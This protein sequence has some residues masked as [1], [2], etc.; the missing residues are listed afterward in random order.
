MRRTTLALGALV[1][2]LGSALPAQT[3]AITGGTVYPVSGPKI[4]NGTVIITNGR[5]AAVGA[6]LA[7]PAGATR[8]DATGK[9]VT[10]GLLVAGST[11]GLAEAGGPQFSGGYNDSRARGSD[12]VSASFKA[13]EGVNPA[14]TF[15]RKN[16][17]AG[18]TTIGLTAASGYIGGQA[19]VLHLTGGTVAE[20][21]VKGSVAMLASLNPGAANTQSRGEMLAKLREVLSDARA[22]GTRRLQYEAG[23]TRSF[24][25]PRREL[26]ALQPVLAGT[27]PLIVSVSRAS[28]IRL[29]LGIANEFKLRLVLNEADEGWMVADA[30][31]LAG[32]PVMVGAMNNIPQSFDALNARQDNAALL[33]KAGVR[34]V[35][36]NNGPAGADAYNIQ[37]IRQEAG[38]AVAYGMSWDDALRAIT[39]VPAEVLGVAD[40][41]GSLQVGRDADVVVWDGDPFE[42]STLA[43]QVFIRGV[44][45]TGDSREDALMKRYVSKPAKF[46]GTP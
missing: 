11:I 42:F 4:T 39:L 10:P 32:V 30:I 16:V 33:R 43:E 34:V 38:N 12:G 7:I 3:I 13:W 45:Q 44:L 17:Q 22:Y 24:A 29:A 26:E 18:V 15:F 25:L 23:N 9:W 41:V 37:N 2:S 46:L 28:D 5:I 1:A 19:A 6:G 31:A 27:M 36:V 14:N 40:R 21:L 20:M 8:V 35:L